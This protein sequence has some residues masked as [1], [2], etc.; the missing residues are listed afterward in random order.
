MPARLEGFG[1]GQKWQD[2][3]TDYYE[4][5]LPNM[6]DY[7]M[8]DYYEISLILSGD[9]KVLLS[10]TARSGKG[11]K[12]VLLRPR[13][14]H[15]ILCE[16][17]MLYRRRN[18]LFSPEFLADYTRDLQRLLPAFGKNGAILN[19]EQSECQRYLSII[20]QIDSEPD[21]FRQKMLLLY[22]LSLVAECAKTEV[23]AAALPAFVSGALDYIAEHYSEKIVAEKLA[24]QLN[25]GRTTLMTVF[26]KYTGLT[27]NE[28]ITRYRLKHAIE[29]LGQGESEP[30]VARA[31]GFNDTCNMIRCFKKHLG[32]PPR[33]YLTSKP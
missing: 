15:F 25:V 12:L 18:L 5:F 33:R 27:V 19:I 7:H 22:F 32:M 26:K 6:T 10:D 11:C 2:V 1:F 24:W 14:P 8:H 3:T 13:T 29:A 31:C 16:P 9:V 17:D 30:E 20:E 21:A 28:Y 4:G 23:G